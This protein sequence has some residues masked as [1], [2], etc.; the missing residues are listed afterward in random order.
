M[1]WMMLMMDEKETDLLDASH[2]IYKSIHL[3]L[4]HLP[5]SKSMVSWSYSPFRLSLCE[6]MQCHPES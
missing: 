4:C 5:L 1:D 6:P 2:L 3:E